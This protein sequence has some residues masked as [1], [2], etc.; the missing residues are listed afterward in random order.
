M[1][2]MRKRPLRDSFAD[3]VR[4]VES[5]PPARAPRPVLSRDGVLTHQNGRQYREVGPVSPS[6]ALELGVLGAV[7][8]WDS[9]GCGGGCGFRWYSAKDVVEMASSGP[10]MLV[11]RKREPASL[12]EWRTDSG[13]TLILA[14][15]AVRW[16]SRMG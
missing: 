14:Q 2:A 15:G 4:E 1:S 9:C 11:A 5:R 6:R 16:A 3:I 8:A 13:A 10:P 7:A 12:S